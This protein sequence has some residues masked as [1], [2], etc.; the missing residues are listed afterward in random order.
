MSS[1]IDTQKATRVG[2]G[3]E[4]LL[5]DTITYS[6]P[7]ALTTRMVYEYNQD[8]G[9]PTIAAIIDCIYTDPTKTVLTSKTRI[10]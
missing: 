7:D 6:Y 8:P 9:I 4:P 3:M 10:T 2:V 1:P 5:F